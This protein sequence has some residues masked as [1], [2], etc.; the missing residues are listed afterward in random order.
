MML[1]IQF[2]QQYPY[3]HNNSSFINSD[4]RWEDI[5]YSVGGGGGV[6]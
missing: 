3:K 1:L 2:S 6:Y 5:I 4:G